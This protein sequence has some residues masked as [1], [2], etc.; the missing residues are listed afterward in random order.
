[1]QKDCS[2][3]VALSVCRA[4]GLAANTIRLHTLKA[5][6]SPS[7]RTGVGSARTAE[8]ILAHQDPAV[9]RPKKFFYLFRP[10]ET[11]EERTFDVVV[12]FILVNDP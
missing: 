6:P 9:R 8:R 2:A 7:F 12:F 5:F 1:M 10:E 3:A 11:V 4:P